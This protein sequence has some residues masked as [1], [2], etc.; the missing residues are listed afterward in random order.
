[1]KK[2]GIKEVVATGICAALVFV[3]LR[4]VAIPTP[5]PDTP[6]SIHNGVLAFFAVLFGPIVG[7]LGGLIGNLLVDVT[8]GW[9]VWWSWIIA[10]GLFGLIVGVG[11]K[12]IDLNKGV[13]GKKEIIRLNVV[14]VIGCVICWG[15][16][17]PVLDIIIYS[18]PADKVFMQGL[19][20]GVSAIVSVA[21]VG[22]L[23]C[24]VYAS[25]RPQAGSLSKKKD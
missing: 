15:V 13:F 21:I 3:L 18:E 19:L 17:A 7:F 4:F 20:V 14:Q 22:T 1:M 9:G 6:L 24:K 16:V 25:S 12:D 11:C 8:A 2:F 23:I 10:T 5:L